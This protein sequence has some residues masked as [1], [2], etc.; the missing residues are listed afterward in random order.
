MTL[1]EAS[2]APRLPDVLTD[3]NTG[4][5]ISLL[6]WQ[7]A[8]RRASWVLG[9]FMIAL[10][11]AIAYL[12]ALAIDPAAAGTFVVIAVALA[13]AQSLGAYWFADRLALAVSGARPA[14][15]D[16]HRYLVNVTEAVAIGAGVPPPKVYVIDSPAPNAFATGRDPRHGAIAVTTGLTQLLDRQELEGVVAHEMAHVKNYDIRFASMLAATIGAIVLLR[17]VAWRGMVYGGRSRRSSTSRSGGGK[18]QGLAMVLLVVLLVLAP[19]LATLLKLAVSRQREYLADA[20][21]AYI[22]RNPEG[23]ANALAKIRDYAG[24]PLEVSEGV[25]HLYFTNPVKRLNVA[26]AFSSHPPIDDRISRLR[27]M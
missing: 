7:A 18:G 5:R 6:D 20:T 8:N 10:L 24:A 21:G 27:R 1:P 23:L 2:S 9:G 19:I 15:A 4:R 26:G 11:A 14:N 16:E 22:T 13:V 25:R 3:P 17:D 12:M